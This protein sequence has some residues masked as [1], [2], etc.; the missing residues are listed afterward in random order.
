MNKLIFYTDGACSGNPG[1]GG[2]GV[3]CLNKCYSQTISEYIE[4]YTINYKYSEYSK[5]TTN[6]REE[7]KAILHVLKLATEH[8]EYNFIIY[9]DS[10]YAVNICNNW[11][12]G[13]QRNGWVR[14]KNQPIENLDLIKE[15]Y[16]YLTT[17]NLH[18]QILKCDGHKNILG[19]ELADAY[20]TN[21]Q[22]KI[23]N[24]IY[25]YSIEYSPIFEVF[26]EEQD[27]TTII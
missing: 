24:L 17:K 25:K 15:I 8:S 26:K 27:V 13:W 14:S 19:N 3:I 23:N 21:N 4:R 20:A 16:K 18:C 22:K 12:Y 5:N 6:N 11:I 7:L 1:P 10:A 2:Y 9:S